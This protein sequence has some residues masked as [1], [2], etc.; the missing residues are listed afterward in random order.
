MIAPGAAILNAITYIIEAGSEWISYPL[1]RQQ[2]SEP[3]DSLSGWGMGG[4]VL[5]RFGRPLV[6]TELLLEL[7]EDVCEVVRGNVVD[8][9][10]FER[11][12]IRFGFVV[13]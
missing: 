3:S 10:V 12:G 9:Q 13:S 11:K 8:A 1:A 5:Q 6:T 7:A 2:L 4:Q